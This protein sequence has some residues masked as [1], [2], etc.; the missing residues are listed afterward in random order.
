MTPKNETEQFVDD[1]TAKMKGRK[2]SGAVCIICCG[3]LS[4]LRNDG[5]WSCFNPKE[6]QQN[7][8]SGA[9]CEE[10]DAYAISLGWTVDTK[11]GN[12]RC[13]DCTAKKSDQDFKQYVE[14]Q[15]ERVG[16]YVP[17]ELIHG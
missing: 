1:L 12:H 7:A 5:T 11:E 16:M 14:R 17:L 13:P 15:N 8:Y 6:A 4:L 9:S 3:C 10:A 2:P